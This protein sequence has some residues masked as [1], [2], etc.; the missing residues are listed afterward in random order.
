MDSYFHD[1]LVNKHMS[2][3]HNEII[4]MHR[5]H[6]KNNNLMDGLNRADVSVL[7]PLS[8]IPIHSNTS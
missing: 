7:S 6:V 4:E 2:I 8:E 1:S 5:E 3:A